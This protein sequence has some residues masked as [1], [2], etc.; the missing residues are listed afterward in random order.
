MCQRYLNWQATN[1]DA[2]NNTTPEKRMGAFISALANDKKRPISFTT[3]KAYWNAIVYF[4]NDFKGTKLGKVQAVYAKSH[5]RIFTMLSIDQAKDLWAAMPATQQENYRLIAKLMFGTGMRIESEVLRLRIKDVLFAEG[6]IA[7]QEGKGDKAGF[8]DMPKTLIDDLKAQ[9]A[10]AR[11]QYNMDRNLNRNG[12]FTPGGISKKYPA[13]PTSWEWYWLFPAKNETY[14]RDEDNIKRRNHIS[15]DDVQRAFRDARR[16]A[17]LPESATPHMMRHMYATL[18]IKN[19]MKKFADAGLLQDI[20]DL[21]A[22]C[23][24]KLRIKLRHVSD[25]TVDTYIHLAMEKNNI[26]DASPLDLI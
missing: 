22:F 26:T 21:Y 12:V 5:Q 2:V 19:L 18:Y 8:V 4:Y 20:P 7:V 1:W 17:K 11:T 23:K 13:Y 24:N 9:I 25:K 6:L 15:V 10:Y 3:Q 16:S 14:A